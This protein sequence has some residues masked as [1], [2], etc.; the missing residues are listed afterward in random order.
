MV[1]ILLLGVPADPWTNLDGRLNAP[2]GTPQFPSILNGYPAATPP[3]ARVRWP[4][5]TGTQ[6]QWEV[7]GVDY[8]AGIDRSLYPTNANLKDPYPGGNLHA[9]LVALGASPSTVPSGASAQVSIS[10]GSGIVFDGWDFGL[11]NGLNLHI[12][13][14]SNWT[15]QNCR[16]KV[17]SNQCSNLAVSSSVTG[18]TIQNI[19]VDGSQLV[20]LP[21]QA[22]L[23][24][25]AGG[26]TICKYNYI[27]DIWFQGV[28]IGCDQNPTKSYFLNNIFWNIGFAAQASGH[29]DVIQAYSVSGGVPTFLDLQANWNLIYQSVAQASGATGANTQGFS[30][31]T[32]GNTASYAKI[33]WQNNTYIV[34]AGSN[35]NDMFI[36]DLSEDGSGGQAAPV[37]G[38]IIGSN[39]YVDNSANN[40]P[41]PCFVWEIENSAQG[42]EANNFYAGVITRTGNVSMVTGAAANS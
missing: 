17:G 32:G 27:H 12:N 6:P 2:S 22:G 30:F 13:G 14:G 29:G 38:T 39:N 34:L 10:S 9:T 26:D 41:S 33:S 5:L 24:L 15:I 11:H 28:Q 20:V 42:S 40:N 37:N 35:T 18:C 25:D 1:G 36:C 4:T 23:N 19:E 3:S 8:Y 31:T 16:F 7:V 21:A